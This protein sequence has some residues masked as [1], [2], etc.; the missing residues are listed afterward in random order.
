MRLLN[1]PWLWLALA[2]LFV[3]GAA[4]AQTPD[5]E[6]LRNSQLEWSRSQ[7]PP[8]GSAASPGPVVM[9]EP[10]GEERGDEAVHRQWS[11][12][13]RD[14]TL[15]RVM[16]RWAVQAQYQLIWQVDRDFPIESEVI[17]EGGF[18]SAVAEV[19]S[20]VALTDYPLQAVFNA[21]AR[22]LRVIRF[23]DETTR[24]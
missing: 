22:V 3:S 21:N 13:M 4:W 10:V 23:L 14:K 5:S 17:Y 24:R 20:S 16:S 6:V 1:T 19:M 11:I 7:K 9:P 18:R 8:L 2:L 12:L 15:Y